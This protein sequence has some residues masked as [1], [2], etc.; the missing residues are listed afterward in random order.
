MAAHKA[1]LVEEAG[2]EE[3]EYDYDDFMDM[4][5]EILWF[6]IHIRGAW[7]GMEWLG[8]VPQGPQLDVGMIDEDF[9]LEG[10]EEQDGGDVVTPKRRP[11]KT[12]LHRREKHGAVDGSDV[13]AAGLLPGLGTMFQP[14]IDWLS[15]ERQ[16]DF[17]R[18]KR[19]V[20]AT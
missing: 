7:G 17:V 15:E 5:D 13:G 19:Q 11:A 14:S 12:P 6:K 18:W 2:G 20:L 16:E 4:R 8:N 9:D 10:A 1:L 3:V